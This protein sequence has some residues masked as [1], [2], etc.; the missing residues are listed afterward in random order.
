[1]I[2]LLS[3][4]SLTPNL[5]Q[6]TVTSVPKADSTSFFRNALGHVSSLSEELG[7][8]GG[9]WALITFILAVSRMDSEPGCEQVLVFGLGS[10]AYALIC[11]AGLLIA[12][13]IRRL[14]HV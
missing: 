7:W 12:R 1:M 4:P 13:G 8:A 5:H 11:V 9:F 10:V 2:A 14:A 6:E 3:P